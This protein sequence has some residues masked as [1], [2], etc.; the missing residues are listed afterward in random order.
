MVVVEGD[1]AANSQG[2]VLGR[3]RSRYGQAVVTGP[4]ADLVVADESRRAVRT[5]E[6]ALPWLRGA[7]VPSVM[8]SPVF[9]K[10]T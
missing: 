1:G 2:V 6:G 10:V 7:V 8:P 5:G 9:E 4:V 3:L